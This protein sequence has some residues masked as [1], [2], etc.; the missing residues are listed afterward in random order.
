[1]ITTENVS[2]IEVTFLKCHTENNT[3]KANHLI[4]VLKIIMQRE[5][6]EPNKMNV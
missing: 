4:N 2:F 1:M 6:G 3:D 5:A